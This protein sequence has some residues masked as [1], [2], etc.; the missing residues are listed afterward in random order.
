M[1]GRRFL[2]NSHQ[3]FN[4]FP[5]DSDISS[6]LQNII[7]KCNNIRLGDLSRWAS[8]APRYES[9]KLF[10]PKLLGPVIAQ[11]GVWAATMGSPTCIVN[12][13]TNNYNSD[14]DDIHFMKKSENI[15]GY[16][17]WLKQNRPPIIAHFLGDAIFFPM[18]FLIIHF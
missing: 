13:K 3:Y 2:K 9:P 6:I 15:V 12:I 16:R 17:R 4:F 8:W 14:D 11:H 1:W 18:F 10:E 5:R 7:V